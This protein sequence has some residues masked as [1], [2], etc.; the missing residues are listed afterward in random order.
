MSIHKSSAEKCNL[1]SLIVCTLFPVVVVIT[2]NIEYVYQ[3]VLNSD[4]V[5]G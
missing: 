4:D 3:F 1:C 5:A 2:C